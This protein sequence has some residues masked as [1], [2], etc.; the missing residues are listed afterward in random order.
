M[1]RPGVS[2][3]IVGGLAATLVMTFFMYGA[4]LIRMPGM[5]IAAMLGSMLTGVPPPVGFAP[6]VLGMLL[7]FINGTIIFPIVFVF[8]LYRFLPGRPWLKGVSWG[9]ILWF[10]S[11][12]AVMPIMGLG[13]FSAAAPQPVLTVLGS[14]IA[15][16]VYGAILGGV[17]GP[18]P[19]VEVVDEPRERLAA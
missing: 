9:V 11:Q 7:H 17:T 4:P 15:H 12:V 18:P 1:H 10:L 16:L 14:L 13:L 19:A 6:W 2:R 8:L 5:D 3:A